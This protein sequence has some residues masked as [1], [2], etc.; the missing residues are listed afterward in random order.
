MALLGMPEY[1][2]DSG[3]W[4][5]VIPAAPLIALS[6]SVPSVPVPERTIPM[7]FSFWSSASERKK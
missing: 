3:A 6:P 5:I 2:A 7:A 4:A 1:L